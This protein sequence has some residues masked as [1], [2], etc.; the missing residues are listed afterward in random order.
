MATY[1]PS[2]TLKL[3]LLIYT[4]THLLLITVYSKRNVCFEF[5]Y[6]SLSF[7]YILRTSAV[8]PFPIS[9]VV[10]CQSTPWS[11]VSSSG[12]TVITSPFVDERERT[13]I[14]GRCSSAAETCNIEVFFNLRNQE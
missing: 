9:V 11:I 5:F 4:L 6:C 8:A 7:K 10:R 2:V 1:S 14:T 13:T 3:L 12:T